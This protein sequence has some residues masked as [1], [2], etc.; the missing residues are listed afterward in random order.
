MNHSNKI[1]LV[2]SIRTWLREQGRHEEANSLDHTTTRRQ[3]CLLTHIDTNS[4][5]KDLCEFFDVPYYRVGRGGG[6][7]K[8]CILIDVQ[9][10][11][12]T[13]FSI[14]SSFCRHVDCGMEPKVISR[15]LS[16]GGSIV[17][18]MGKEKYLVPN[19]DVDLLRLQ[20]CDINIVNIRLELRYRGYNVTFRRSIR[21]I[22][23]M[24]G[25]H[26]TLID[27]YNNHTKLTER[28][29]EYL[30]IEFHS[31][32]GSPRNSTPLRTTLYNVHREPMVFESILS[33]ARYLRQNTYS[34][35]A[36]CNH[37]QSCPYFGDH[38]FI[39]IEGY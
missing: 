10:G 37:N 19:R 34:L 8:R 32:Q 35:I 13:H 27:E 12:E 24:L 2:D 36:L 16:E 20:P 4:T 15:L 17:R 38:Y 28:I 26:S 23:N 7:P 30:N 6:P 39:E 21:E 31:R 14:I 22:A 1:R 18:V 5:I 9:T 11:R 33:A 29:C 25:I 3:L